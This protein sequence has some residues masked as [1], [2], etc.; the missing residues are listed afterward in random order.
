NGGPRRPA[1][2]QKAT[3]EEQ[4]SFA[5]NQGFYDANGGKPSGSP[6]ADAACDERKNLRCTKTH[7]ISTWNVHR[8][9]QRKLD[10]IKR[11]MIRLNIDLLGISELHWKDKGHFNL[12]DFSVY[13]SGHQELRRNG[14]ALIAHKNI[15]HA[16]ES[17]T[18]ISNRMMAIRIRGKPLNVTVL[19]VYAPTTDAPE[20]E[21]EQ[22][23]AKIEEALEQVPKKDIIYIMGNFNAKVASQ[24]EANIIGRCGLGERNEAGNRL[25]QFCHENHLRVSQQ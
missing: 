22:F 11:E 18:T 21:R 8:M 4:G 2:I 19:Q 10:I 16:V 17:Y 14:V 3:G 9:S 1:G 12:D 24:E 5:S 6:D 23:Y 20:D 7:K 15:A 25:V 13:Y